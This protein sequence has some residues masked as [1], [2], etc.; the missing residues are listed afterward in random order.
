[1]SICT[2]LEVYINGDEGNGET[3]TINQ[4]NTPPG[5][6]ALEC[7]EKVYRLSIESDCSN[8]NGAHSSLIC[9][10][11]QCY[12]CNQYGHVE[13]ICRNCMEYDSE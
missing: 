4:A 6:S 3:Y 12:A 2:D 9:P 5:V 7:V 11:V 10:L 1:M 8:C 13:I